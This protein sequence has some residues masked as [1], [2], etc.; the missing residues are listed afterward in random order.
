[1]DNR[2]GPTTG[3][4]SLAKPTFNDVARSVFRITASNL[5]QYTDLRRGAGEIF[6][7]PIP[8]SNAARPFNIEQNQLES[9]VY[10]TGN[11]RTVLGLE[12]RRKSART[13]IY[14]VTYTLNAPDQAALGGFNFSQRITDSLFEAINKAVDLVVIETVGRLRADASTNSSNVTAGTEIFTQGPTDTNPGEASTLPSNTNLGSDV[15]STTGLGPEGR[16][17]HRKYD[18]ITPTNQIELV[19]GINSA[20]IDRLTLNDIVRARQRIIARS[21]VTSDIGLV[22]L[23][24]P[25]SAVS[26]W[27]DEKIR[28]GLSYTSNE[29]LITGNI[30]LIGG[31]RILQTAI[32]PPGGA[33][34]MSERAI[35]MVLANN[36]DSGQ[37]VDV[38]RAGA[39]TYGAWINMGSV[40]LFPEEVEFLHLRS[41]EFSLQVPTSPTDRYH[42]YKY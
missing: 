12:F 39:V 21:K 31:C 27:Y 5:A 14:G 26:M 35:G 6:F 42:T 3:I 8:V 16:V 7:D 28:N 11:D 22:M 30:G 32:L 37:K 24:N 2:V 41:T 19:A 17:D 40:L 10:D 23:V 38:S 9:T 18:R 4:P 25:I 13:Q 34:I 29:Y 1:M 33:I 20:T 36:I 15:D